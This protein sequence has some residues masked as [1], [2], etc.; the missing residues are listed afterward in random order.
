[1]IVLFHGDHPRDIIKG[2]GP[3]TEVSIIRDLAHFVDEAVEVWCWDAVDGGD[4][5]GWAEAVLV[6]W[7]AATL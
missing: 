5:V 1:M 7:G 3:Q 6:R 2:H 4:E